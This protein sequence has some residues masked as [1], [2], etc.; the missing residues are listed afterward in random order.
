MPN[1]ISNLTRL[2]HRPWT[3]GHRPMNL[4]P[5]PSLI[6]VMFCGLYLAGDDNVELAAEK[7]SGIQMSFPVLCGIRATH[8]RPCEEPRSQISIEGFE[9]LLQLGQFANVESYQRRFQELAAIVND[10]PEEF[11]VRC[12]MK[13]LRKEIKFGVEKYK[14]TTVDQAIGL[15]RLQEMTL[16]V[17]ARRSHTPENIIGEKIEHSKSTLPVRS[18]VCESVPMV[19]ATSKKEIDEPKANREQWNSIDK[20]CQEIRALFSRLLEVCT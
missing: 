4:S 8:S 17:V 9:E 3:T 2:D 10:L 1:S 15:A 14:P 5:G 18:I 13:G 7:D 19:G 6:Q 16:E 11:R 20:D 12:F